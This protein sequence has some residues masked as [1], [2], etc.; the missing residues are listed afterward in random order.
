MSSVLS[1]SGT[2]ATLLR[3]SPANTQT[4]GLENMFTHNPRGI[5]SVIVKSFAN[6]FVCNIY[7]YVGSHLRY[8]ATKENRHFVLGISQ[9]ELEMKSF[10]RAGKS[11]RNRGQLNN[12]EMHR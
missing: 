5:D 3:L 1:V 8:G 9:T 7:I 2:L 6:I 12:G 11:N 10:G 4:F